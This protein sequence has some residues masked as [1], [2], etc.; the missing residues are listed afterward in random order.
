GLE[1][2]VVARILDLQILAGLVKE[3]DLAAVGLRDA[4]VVLSGCVVAHIAVIVGGQEVYL[5]GYIANGWQIHVRDAFLVPE[6]APLGGDA[7]VEVSGGLLRDHAHRTTL[8]ILAEQ[9]PLRAAQ[10]LD[11]LEVIQLQRDTGLAAVID[12]IDVDRNRI[13]V[14]DVA[15]VGIDEA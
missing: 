11:T 5:G 4:E 7:Q 12:V 2:R 6:V 10:N 15:A 13:L 14:G 1:A 9:G 3:R 8:G